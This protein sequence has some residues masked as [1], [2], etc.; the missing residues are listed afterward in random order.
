MEAAHCVTPCELRKRR[1]GRKEMPGGDNK[2]IQTTANCN[3]F[4][5]MPLRGDSYNTRYLPEDGSSVGV[6]TSFS[7]KL[8]C[9]CPGCRGRS[10]PRAGVSRFI[11]CARRRKCQRNKGNVRS[12]VTTHHA[13]VAS[14]PR[15]FIFTA[16]FTLSQLPRPRAPSNMLFPPG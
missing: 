4:F 15:R 7:N 3:Y 8:G 2:G 14:A 13:S 12:R 1:S 6:I 10:R 16:L 9:Q 11:L 5:M